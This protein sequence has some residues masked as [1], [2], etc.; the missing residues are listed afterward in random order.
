A[1]GFPETRLLCCCRRS[2]AGAHQVECHG[3]ARNCSL[4]R[5]VRKALV[6]SYTRPFGEVEN[7]FHSE[8]ARGTPTPSR[9][10]CRAAFSLGCWLMV[11]PGRES[12]SCG[13]A[14]CR[15]DRAKWC[16]ADDSSTAHQPE[17]CAAPCV[18][19]ACPSPSPFPCPQ[20]VT[21]VMVKS[22]CR[23]RARTHRDGG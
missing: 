6:R 5:R 23:S 21:N 15:R 9:I 11:V 19:K 3:R 14:H 1:P 8:L 4:D 13:R 10:G 22:R 7:L 12:W 17:A 2:Q 18:P 20:D 16:L